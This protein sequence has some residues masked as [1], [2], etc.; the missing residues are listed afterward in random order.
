MDNHNTRLRFR[1]GDQSQDLMQLGTPPRRVMLSLRQ[2]T[3]SAIVPNTV[4]LL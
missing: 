4:P 1:V 2:V 3:F